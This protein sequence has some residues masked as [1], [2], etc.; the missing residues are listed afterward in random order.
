[1]L[2][3]SSE[4]TKAEVKKAYHKLAM[5]YHPDHNQ[6]DT[7]MQDKFQEITEAY[8]HLTDDLN[9]YYEILGIA[10]KAPFSDVKR[11]YAAHC[12]RYHPALQRGDAAAQAA[13]DKMKA[14][15]DYLAQHTD[16]QGTDNQD[17]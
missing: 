17:W 6:G 7:S 5:K 1:M 14:A 11:A 3:L 9:V 4:A 8:Q 12:E 2:G 15:Y 10:P 13:L 16:T